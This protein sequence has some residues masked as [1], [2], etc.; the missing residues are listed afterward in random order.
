LENFFSL[1]PLLSLPPLPGL[2]NCKALSFLLSLG[3][4]AAFFSLSVSWQNSAKHPLKKYLF[5]EKLSFF[6][7]S[8]QNTDTVFFLQPGLLL[9]LTGKTHSYKVSESFVFLSVNKFTHS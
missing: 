9:E 4:Y 7:N 2:Q 5:T 8:F 3:T 1:P 6:S